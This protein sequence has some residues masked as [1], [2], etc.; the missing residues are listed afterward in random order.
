MARPRGSDV[1]VSAVQLA[2]ALA[3]DELHATFD[4]RPRP[5]PARCDVDRRARLSA[6]RRS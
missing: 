3:L 4:V 5:G 6:L 2:T 1:G